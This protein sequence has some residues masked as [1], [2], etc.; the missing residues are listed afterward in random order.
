[1]RRNYAEVDCERARNVVA[2]VKPRAFSVRGSERTINLF[3]IHVDIAQR[4]QKFDDCVVAERGRCGVSGFSVSGNHDSSVFY[5]IFEP[6]FFDNRQV[7]GGIGDTRGADVRH[8]VG[9]GAA[10]NFDVA[11]I[12]FLKRYRRDAFFAVDDG[13]VRVGR[14]SRVGHFFDGIE[15]FYTTPASF[16]VAADD[17]SYAFFGN[18]T[19]VKKGL[20]GVQTRKHGAAVVNDA[21]AVNDVARN[22]AVRVMRPAVAHGHGVKVTE[23]TESLAFADVRNAAVTVK[24][25]RLKTERLRFA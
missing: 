2:K 8:D 19:F 13:E 10:R 20:Y 12:V 16:F 9:T 21:S 14:E 7:V 6:G 18:K 4:F 22:F 24:V 1:M 25:F 11:R 23:N 3:Q 5:F 15:M 17:E